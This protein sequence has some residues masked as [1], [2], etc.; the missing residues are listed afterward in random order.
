MSLRTPYVKRG[1]GPAPIMGQHF[2]SE[3]KRI[4]LEKVRPT[5]GDRIKVE[6]LDADVLPQ[7]PR[8][9][10]YGI[11]IEI[12]PR[13]YPWAGGWVL[14]IEPTLPTGFGRT[15]ETK[16]I[17]SYPYTP[18]QIVW[19]TP[20][21]TYGE[22]HAQRKTAFAVAKML[23][24]KQLGWGKCYLCGNT[25]VVYDENDTCS[26]RVK[27]WVS[28]ERFG[29]YTS[30]PITCMGG[31]QAKYASVRE[32]LMACSQ[33]DSTK[34]KRFGVPPYIVRFRNILIALSLF[35]NH[36]KTNRNTYF[37]ALFTRPYKDAP[38]ASKRSY[39]YVKQ[40]PAMYIAKSGRKI[41]GVRDSFTDK[42]QRRGAVHHEL[43]CANDNVEMAHIFPA[44]AGNIDF[45]VN[46][47][48]HEK[49]LRLDKGITDKNLTTLISKAKLTDSL[50]HTGLYS[51]AHL[52]SRWR[53]PQLA[54]GMWRHIELGITDSAGNIICI[55]HLAHTTGFDNWEKE[56]TQALTLNTVHHTAAK[57]EERPMAYDF[58]TID[59]SG[60]T[61]GA[62]INGVDADGNW[63]TSVESTCG[64]RSGDTRPVSINI[65]PKSKIRYSWLDVRE[66]LRMEEPNRWLQNYRRCR[67]IQLRNIMYNFLYE[68]EIHEPLDIDEKR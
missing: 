62:F 1:G 10:D 14:K 45:L 5:V 54:R 30:N 31:D 68:C 46:R 24:E 22:L 29:Y 13:P 23:R 16:T 39:V 41:T 44:W 11:V 52:P 65:G 47:G 61:Y 49:F 64:D 4:N 58:F 37:R 48:V 53:E 38:G 63:Q 43:P 51:S 3:G 60:K 28:G 8:A 57:H 33:A 17:V 7:D 59:T 12:V 50:T 66:K 19:W 25:H 35:A 6:Y 2:E 27:S 32:L 36:T 20:I 26:D 55:N 9:E 40:L 15:G 34:M 56:A 42:F 18:A 21:F 67:W